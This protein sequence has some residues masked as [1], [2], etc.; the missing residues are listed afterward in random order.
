MGDTE[1]ALEM[2]LQSREA[3]AP[4]EAALQA[5]KEAQILKLHTCDT[6]GAPLS[7]FPHDGVIRVRIKV[8]LNATG[9]GTHLTLK[10]FNA[11]LETVLATHDFEPDGHSLVPSEAGV[12]EFEATVPADLL[13][14]AKY[15]LG[16]EVS[17]QR[18]VR[19]FRLLDKMDHVGEFEVYDNGSLLS[20]FSIPWQGLVHGSAITWSRL[21]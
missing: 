2:Y 4:E 8:H 10:I 7:R 12:Y 20:Q 1:A 6:T 21:E 9:F 17:L 11:N 14:P 5:W 16:A 18:Q 3:A 15:Y 13:P 19:G